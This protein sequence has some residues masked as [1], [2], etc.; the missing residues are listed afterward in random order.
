MG[1]GERGREARTK[2]Q[3]CIDLTLVLEAAEEIALQ[4]RA[5][6]ATRPITV[7][8]KNFPAFWLL[9]VSFRPFAGLAASP[10]PFSIVTAMAVVGR[11]EAEPLRKLIHK[12]DLPGR[13]C[14]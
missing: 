3:V 8:P 5:Y 10:W 14:R 7:Q 12:N 4:W 2:W 9:T 1:I 13:Q 11:D 6:R